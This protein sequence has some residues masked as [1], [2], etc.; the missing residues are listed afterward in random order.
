M[1]KGFFLKARKRRDDMLIVGD[2]WYG[3]EDEE[4]GM[5][6]VIPP[7]QTPMEPMEYLSRSWSISASEISKALLAGGKKRN[8]VMERFPELFIPDTLV[9]AA[10][11]AC[12]Y[13]KRVSD[14]INTCLF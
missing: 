9:F 4:A 1:E 12:N 6:A 5:V 10:S 8:F 3:G 13:Q 2:D 11:N 7:P 14:S